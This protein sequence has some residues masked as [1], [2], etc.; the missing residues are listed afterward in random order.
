MSIKIFGNLL[1]NYHRGRLYFRLSSKY[2]WQF[3]NCKIERLWDL[4]K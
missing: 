2:K 4:R 1:F 3:V